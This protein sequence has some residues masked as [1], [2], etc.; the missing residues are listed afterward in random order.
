ME[1]GK[2]RS[3]E[4][5]RPDRS[6]TVRLAEHGHVEMVVHKVEVPI[7]RGHQDGVGRD[8]KTCTR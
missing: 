5:A 7:L 1:R 3:P 8:Y 6:I 4:G 2:G